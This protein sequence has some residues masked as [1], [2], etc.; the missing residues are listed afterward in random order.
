MLRSMGRQNHWQPL[1]AVVRDLVARMRL[2]ESA[3]TPQGKSQ[4][5]GQDVENGCRAGQ[6]HE[7]G[8]KV[9]PSGGIHYRWGSADRL[10]VSSNDGGALTDGGG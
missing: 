5:H 1:G 10:R 6:G 7:A 4:R 8:M 9:R 3:A 2:N